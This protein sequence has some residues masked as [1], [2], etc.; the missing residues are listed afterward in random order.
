VGD[1]GS[2]LAV[3]MN[4]CANPACRAREAELQEFQLALGGVAWNMRTKLRVL[5]ALAALKEDDVLARAWRTL[6]DD[7]GLFDEE[8]AA[9][10]TTPEG[11]A[12]TAR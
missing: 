4:D 10:L 7:L 2:L 12:A 1:A 9:W 11:L 6:L 8:I 5:E 3:R